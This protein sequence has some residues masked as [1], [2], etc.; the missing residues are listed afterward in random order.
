MYLAVESSLLFYLAVPLWSSGTSDKAIQL[1]ICKQ[2]N[3]DMCM[4]F[5][6]LFQF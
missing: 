5:E 4:I 3:E 2:G 1:L 6:G